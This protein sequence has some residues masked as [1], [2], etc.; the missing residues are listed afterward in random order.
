MFGDE[1]TTTP[2]DETATAPQS[3]SAARPVS[4]DQ[5]RSE[6]AFRFNDWAAI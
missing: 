5:V 1:K 2:K 6:G 3:S 4:K